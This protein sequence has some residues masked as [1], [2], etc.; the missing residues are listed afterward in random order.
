M[1]TECG[2]SPNKN[3]NVFEEIHNKKML[4]IILKHINILNEYWFEEQN[5]L[6]VFKWVENG[7]Y[8]LLEYFCSNIK[9]NNLLKEIITFNYSGFVQY[10]T[11]YYAV[12]NK[13]YNIIEYLL[14]LSTIKLC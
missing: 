10:N 13:H 7:N 5:K 14:S 4:Q 3:F 8:E 12:H 1:F 2:K 11:L 9:N 6:F